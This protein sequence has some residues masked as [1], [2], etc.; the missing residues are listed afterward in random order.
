MKYFVV[1]AILLVFI[2]TYIQIAKYFQIV[3]QPNIRS[4]HSRITIRGGGIIFPISALIW[5]FLSGFQYPMFFLGLLIISAISFWDDI[6]QLSSRIRLVI[7]SFA[8]CC[9]FF[10]LG[11]HQYSWLIWALVFVASIGIINA[12]NFMDGINGITGAYSLSVLWGLW[13]I[14]TYQYQFIDNDLIYSISI[15]IVVFLL[16]NFRKKAICFAGDVGAISIAFILIFLIAKL[17]IITSNPLYLLLLSLYGIDS[18]LT[19]LYR[20]W[21]RENIF[22]AHR[23]H[24][25]QFL[26]N[27]LQIPHVIV[28]STYALIQ[29]S[30]SLLIFFVITKDSSNFVLWGIGLGTPLLLV[31]IYTVIRLKISKMK[32]NNETKLLFRK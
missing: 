1:F 16:F 5:F 9:L 25:Y 15:S 24:L 7:Q 17:I 10:D 31:L 8:I 13:M 2:Y 12:F 19:I 6:S 29:F 27:E 18:L 4:S 28:A 26:A 20:L 30:I 32:V 21:N 14:N 23:K 3:D 22:E 11:F